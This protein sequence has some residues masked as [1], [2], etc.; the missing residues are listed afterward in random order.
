MFNLLAV[1]KNGYKFKYKTNHFTYLLYIY[2]YIYC[3]TSL[4]RF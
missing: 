4:T 3:K 2:I 1:I